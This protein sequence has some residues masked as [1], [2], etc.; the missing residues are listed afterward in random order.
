[1]ATIYKLKQENGAL[2]KKSYT[3]GGARETRKK[4]EQ[5]GIKTS[6]IAYEEYQVITDTMADI[7]GVVNFY[8]IPNEKELKAM[9]KAEQKK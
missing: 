9:L 5:K 1:M 3:L 2:S 6:I 7:T 8:R 4:L